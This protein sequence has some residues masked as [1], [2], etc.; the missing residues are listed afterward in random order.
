[1]KY[2]KYKY[3]IEMINTNTNTTM[4]KCPHNIHY[5]LSWCPEIQ[6]L[7][8]CVIIIIYLMSNV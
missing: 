4:Q 2:N 3:S 6:W 1:M 5:S 7:M 8:Q